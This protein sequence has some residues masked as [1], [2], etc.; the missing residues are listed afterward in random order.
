MSWATKHT[1][2][3]T[4][5]S[6]SDIS[7]FFQFENQREPPSLAN[8]GRLRSRTKSDI[9]NCTAVHTT[10]C[11]DARNVTVQIFDMVHLT[12]APTFNDYGKMHLVPFVNSQLTASVERVDAVLDT[13]PENKLKM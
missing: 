13:Y 9:L 4:S 7:D 5:E 3:R 1:K 10:A 12:R 6:E 2:A 8:R 11:T